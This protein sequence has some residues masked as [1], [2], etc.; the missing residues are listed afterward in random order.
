MTKLKLGQ[1]CYK[2]DVITGDIIESTYG[3]HDWLEDLGLIKP[4]KHDLQLWLSTIKN[5]NKRR[6]NEG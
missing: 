3:G 5:E 4:T 2:L 1:A 6:N